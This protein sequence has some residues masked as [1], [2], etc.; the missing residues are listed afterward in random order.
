MNLGNP[1]EFTIKE[2]AEKVINLTNS[3]SKIIYK[4]L[5]QDDPRQRQP[6]IDY[7]KEK[8]NWNPKVQLDKGLKATSDYFLRRYS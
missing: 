6:N 7:A 8:L 1:N 4:D 3:R 2:L 5:P